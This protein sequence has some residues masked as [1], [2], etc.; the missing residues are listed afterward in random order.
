M[1]PA[2]CLVSLAMLLV[3]VSLA[4]C[5]QSSSQ[6]ATATVDVT[7]VYQ[8]V[9]A[10][11]TLT[12]VGTPWLTTVPAPTNDQAAT[13]TAA[14]PT[15]TETMASTALAG[16]PTLAAACDQ[17][18]AGNPIDISVPDDSVMR[19]GQSFTKIWKLQ[20]AGSCTWTQDYEVVF[21][22]GDKMGAPDLVSLGES[23]AP[24][25]SVDIVIEMTAPQ[26]PGSYQGNWKLRNPAGEFF[27]IGP[28][29]N[30]P[31][32]VRI[33][34]AE[35]VTST[36][37]LTPLPSITPTPSR[38]PLPTPTD[39]PTPPV[40]VTGEI[41]FTLGDALD[42]DTAELNL[43]AGN[44]LTYAADMHNFH[45]LFPQAGALLGVYGMQ[46]PG[47]ETCR[48]AGMSTAPIAVES[49]TLGAYLCYRTSQ[50]APGWMQVVALDGQN[51]K[52]TVKLLTW[53]MP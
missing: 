21:F 31:F 52:L 18:S 9:S 19:P 10:M 41:Q 20:N 22:Y 37:T 45:W 46:E 14:A 11:L 7:H 1:K 5:R 27:G 49:V 24:G 29:G 32:W 26:E 48:T 47:L 2:P 53:K 51:F 50:G 13:P 17:A 30:S 42:L 15:R 25:R 38:T 34:V 16:S 12:P 6:A 43:A 23:V 36:P 33:I 39:T 44:D 4:G 8:T 3:L 40:R 35:A 28:G